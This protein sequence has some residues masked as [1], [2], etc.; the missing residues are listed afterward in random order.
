MRHFVTLLT[1]GLLLLVTLLMRADSGQLFTA[2]K[3]PSSLI[4]CIVQD[5]NGYI[6]IGTDY[7]LSRF[8]GYHFVNYLHDD[9]DTTT[10]N[11]NTIA[12]F[13]VDSQGRLWIGSAKGLMRYDYGSDK[14]HHYNMPGG[15]TLRVSDIIESR[16][17]DILI[18]SA[19]YGLY[20]IGRGTDKVT[21]LTQYR[22]RGSDEF[23]VHLYE[24]RNGDLWQSSHLST[25]SRYHKEGDRVTLT[26]Y[27]SPCGAPIAFTQRGDKLLI[28]C[29]FGIAQYDYRT[30][31]ISD[32]GYDF[33]ALDGNITIN[34]AMTDS[35]GNSYVGTSE[36]G[37][38]VAWRGT[39]HFV[40]YPGINIRGFAPQ[41]AYIKALL[42]DKDWNLWVSCYKKG[43]LLLA[44]HEQRDFDTWTFESQNY[45]TGSAVSSLAHGDNG[46]T[47]CV[48]QNSGVFRFDRFGH[49]TAHPKAPAG[50]S[51]IYRD[52]HGNYWLGTGNALYAYQ[53]ETGT[54]QQRMAFEG[55]GVYSIADDGQGRL[56]VSVYS[57]GL[58]VLDTRSGSV[59]TLNMNSKAAGG[60]LCN[61]WVRGLY[62]DGGHR[63]W[64]ATSNGVCN[65][66]TL[67]MRFDDLGWDII[68]PDIQANA[69]TADQLGNIVIGTDNGLYRYDTKSKRTSR[70]PDSGVLDGKQVCSLAA[71]SDG[72]LWASTTMGIW[73]WNAD[74][75]QFQGYVSG[76]GLAGHE[77]VLGAMVRMA[78]D[79]ILYG[80]SGGVTTF[81][82]REVNRHHDKVGEAHLT[83]LIV[84]GKRRP[85]LDSTISLPYSENSF[86][87]EFSLLT[88]KHQADI[89]YA[90][91]INGGKWTN[92][93]EGVNAIP[94]NKLEPGTYTLEVR[95]SYNGSL[96][97]RT[98]T[99]VITVRPPWYASTVAYAI[100]CVL[101]VSLL[102][103][104][105]LTYERKRKA[106]L[107]EQKMRFLINA[108]H[109]IRSPLSLIMGPLAKLR[110]KLGNTDC[111]EEID[112]IDRNAQRLMMLVNQ[113]LDERKIDKKQLKLE[114][115]E[116]DL[117]SFVAPII[118]LYK[119]Q[120]EEKHITLRLT[121]AD[122]KPWHS[123]H[124]AVKVWI[125][126]I[127][128]DKVVANLLSN[129][130]KYT[131]D[132]GQI[133]VRVGHGDGTV[134]LTVVDNGPGLGKGDTSR[135][136]D[137]FYQGKNLSGEQHIG[138]GIGLNLC[139]AIVELHHGKIR[140]YNRNDGTHGAC[141]EVTLREGN[142]HFLP[143]ELMETEPAAEPARGKHK[144]TAN[145]N[146]RVLV[147]DDDNEIPKYI[148][149]ELGTWYR[150]SI[151]NDGKEAL[152]KLLTDSYDL[153]ISDV[154]MPVMDGITLL[155]EIK[156]NP[157]ISHIPVILLTSKSDV[158]HRLEGFRRGADAYLAKPFDM[159][160][161]HVLIDNLVDNVR[162]LR[163]KFSGAQEQQDKVQD[164]IVKGN[165]D[166]LMERIMKCVNENLRN[167]DFN[168]E[169][170]TD[171]VG[172][173]RAHL[174]RKMKEITGISTSD[175][176]RNLRLEQ[177]A[178]LIREGS[179][180]VTQ[181]AYSVGFNN[182]A[183]FSTAF[184]KHFG[185]NPT[186]YYETFR[187]ETETSGNDETAD[188]S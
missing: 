83:N 37:V 36:S 99:V 115:Q 138:T 6:W 180:N 136:F 13:L 109:D 159:D 108:T 177:A 50:T 118:R 12:D 166:A 44:D 60:R 32:A 183:H 82:P 131:P 70:Y 22:Q 23:F 80:T 116:T 160:E 98:T 3:L 122:G 170:L 162:R 53:P 5:R 178:K 88:F 91:R 51:I 17:G 11:H 9:A 163:G 134:T 7:G 15:R 101:F 140:A 137:R 176:I 63:L 21:A 30:G 149:S 126:R 33:G 65:L 110:K 31:Q 114:C 124:V 144:T 61:D 64:I 27:Q 38:L 40:P 19:G 164:I 66:N 55:A 188:L 184:K 14:F 181:V 94:F 128:F 161:L 130:M 132:G 2:D 158:A 75:R 49:I 141:F 16:T 69:I 58:Y 123:E 10:I 154:M 185:M 186:E 167:P 42:M 152:G 93:D 96:S 62:F 67:T 112:V 95:A 71:D 173:S 92:T 139:Q 59:T 105:L 47:W 104:V 72:N 56:F 57:K 143:G 81:Y 78:D 129:A 54:A 145:R 85:C 150:F 151:A 165:N 119:F 135:L 182:R 133:D 43:L 39:K 26:R 29:M 18:G 187:K 157:N 35:Q 41:A 87:L 48:V 169:M 153:V 179:I 168:V 97:E 142:S 103:F 120:A 45:N 20:A 121:D 102:A 171:V 148:S 25:F 107:D 24:D 77:Y 79:R 147:V 4:N 28:T 86:T 68:L 84:D 106:D 111:T 89:S 73:Q 46:D 117:A 8:D 90:Y 113:I 146:L 155:K 76:S 1:S 174:H 100:Y 125:D 172:I 34:A 74:R 175:F 52:R 127:N 156:G